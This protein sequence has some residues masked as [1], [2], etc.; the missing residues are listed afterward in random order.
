MLWG[1]KGSMVGWTRILIRQM[2]PHT[3]YII[4]KNVSCIIFFLP[5]LMTKIGKK[6]SL[7][8][9]EHEWMFCWKKHTHL[10]SIN[11]KHASDMM[12][13]QDRSSLLF[14]I[15]NNITTK[16]SHDSRWTFWVFLTMSLI[17]LSSSVA[18]FMYPLSSLLVCT[19]LCDF[20]FI[21]YFD[22]SEEDIAKKN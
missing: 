7:R 17:T 5:I 8:T 18:I 3:Y 9:S 14:I 22:L 1:A 6:L 16:R 2:P 11:F 20:N 10:I 13:W 15:L 4:I 12:G 21:I 19:F